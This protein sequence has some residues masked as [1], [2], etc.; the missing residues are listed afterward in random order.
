M[1]HNSLLDGCLWTSWLDSVS[2]A[3]G[4]DKAG[5]ASCWPSPQVVLTHAPQAQWLTPSR[6]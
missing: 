1:Y 5:V 2:F 6:G 4:G 3:N